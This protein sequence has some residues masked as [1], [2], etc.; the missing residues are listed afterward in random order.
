[1]ELVN[2]VIQVVKLVL[3]L[4]RMIVNRARFLLML[5][6][7]MEGVL[8][9]VPIKK[10]LFQEILFIVKLASQDARLVQDQ[11]KVSANLA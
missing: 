10:V 11:I 1:M 5:F 7:L 8:P 6:L 2:S 9:T 3:A 4:L